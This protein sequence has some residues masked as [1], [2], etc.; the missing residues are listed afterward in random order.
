M[1]GGNSFDSYTGLEIA[2][3]GMSGRFPG[4][5][6]LAQFWENL[7]TGVESISF[8]SEEELIEAGVEPESMNAPGFVRARGILREAEYFDA[9][10]FGYSPAEANIMDPQLRLFHECAMAALEDAGYDPDSYN[11]LIGLYAGAADSIQWRARILT[12]EDC[13]FDMFSRSLYGN[14]DFLA[15]RISYKLNLKGPS[16]SIYT[17]CS[18]SLVAVHMACRS[19]LNGE[20]HMAAAG[21]VTVS[22]PP[23]SGYLYEEGMFVSPDGHCRAFDEA[24]AG[25]VFGDGVGTVVLK[26]LE[27]AI[28]DRDHVY[29]VVK[30]SAINNDGNLKVGFTAPSVKGQVEVIKVSHLM[31]EIEPESIGYV[32]AHG[33]GTTLGDP[34][35]IKALKTA[36]NS[37]KRGFCGLG[38]VKTNVGHLDAAA[39]VA[40]F[41]K[42]A[43]VLQHRLIP[44]TLNFVRA[45]PRLDLE[46]SPFYVVTE[47]REWKQDGG[48]LR[49]G[50]SSFGMGGTNAHVV[51]EEAPAVAESPGSR[52]WQL[53]LLSART[54]KELERLTERMVNFLQENPHICLA[55]AAFTLQVGRKA[56]DWRR[57]TVCSDIEDALL[58]LSSPTAD[59]DRVQTFCADRAERSVV[60][61]FP[62]QGSQYVNMGVELYRTEET[63][64]QEMD[65]CFTVLKSLMGVDVG[66]I[67]YPRDS[68]RRRSRP[69][70]VPDINRTEI[71]QPLI[72]IF[73]YA[74]ARLLM[75][76]GIEPDAMLGHSIG[77]YTAAC[78]AGVFSLED[79]LRL[80]VLRGQLMQRMPG[81]AMLGVSLSEAELRGL[82]PEGL[83][84]AA[85]N[86]P[87]SCVVSGQETVIDPFSRALS[88]KGIAAGR[89]H[90]SHA[91]HSAMM[92]P[93]L[94]E[95]AAEVEKVGLNPPQIAYIANVTGSWITDEAATDPGYWVQHVRRTVQFSAG[96]RELLKER[97]NIF[98]EVGPGRVL[99]T[100]VRKHGDSAVGHMT[101][102]L[103]R[104][105]QE[106][107]ADVGYLLT[108]LGQL[109]L[110][111][112]PIDWGGFYGEEKRRRISLPTYPFERQRYGKYMDGPDKIGLK[113]PLSSRLTEK[114]DFTEWFYIPAWKQAGMPPSASGGGAWADSQIWLLFVDEGG[115]GTRLRDCLVKYGQQV[116]TVAPAGGFNRLDDRRFVIHPARPKDYVRLIDELT[117]S[118]ERPQRI[119]HL[120][121]LRTGDKPEPY[122]SGSVKRDLELGFYSLLYLAQA[123][124]KR[125]PD[126]EWQMRIEVVANNVHSVTGEETL[127][128]GKA[129]VLGLV[130]VISQEYLDIR[131]RHIDMVMPEP[132]EGQETELV[133][134]LLAE[135]GPE[136]GD[137]VVAYRENSRW[138]P[139]FKAAGWDNQEIG[140]SPLR[141]QGTYVITGGLGDIGLALAEYLAKSAGARLM[142]IGRSD[143]PAP[144]ERQAWL[145]SHPQDDRLSRK[146]C[147]LRKIEASGAEV[148]VVRADVADGRQMREAFDLAEERFGRIDGV[149]HAAGVLNQRSLLPL[150]QFTEE[151]CREQFRSKIYG[152]LV[153][154]QVLSGR[155]IDFCL[156]TSSLS[157]V[158]AGLGHGVYSAAN[159]FMDTFTHIQN[160]RDNRGKGKWIS[161]NMDAWQIRKEN[162]A[163]ATPMAKALAGMA[164]TCREGVEAIRA[165]LSRGVGEVDQVVVSTGD[166]ENRLRQWIRLEM[167][168]E[169][170]SLYSRPGLSTPYVAPRN[171]IED[172]IV[173]IF[174]EFF[175]L[176]RVGTHDNFFDLGASSLDMVQLSKKMKRELAVDIPVTT[177]FQYP[178][179]HALAAFLQPDGEAA[180]KP[181]EDSG[182][183]EKIETG[184]RRLENRMRRQQASGGETAAADDR[185]ACH[186]VAV[187]GMAGRFPGAGGVDEFWENL[188][189]GVESLS[190]FSDRELKEMGER[191]DL[192]GDPNYIKVKGVLEDIEYFDPEFFGY[193]PPEAEIMDPQMRVMHECCWHALEQAGYDPLRYKG[194]IGLYVGAANNIDWQGMIFLAG[195]QESARRFAAQH[196]SDKDHISTRLSYNLNLR[197]PSFSLS[198]QCSTS[199]VA[200]HLACEGL[201]GGACDMALAGG[202]SV[203]LPGKSG[204]VYQEGMIVSPD[205]HCRAFD[206]GAE[207]TVFGN[208]A[209]IVV[210][211]R[212]EDAAADRDSLY[213]VI[214]G[215]AI[216]ND[217]RGKVGYTAPG[218][219]G[220]AEVIRTALCAARVEPETISYIETHGT[221][222]AL[223]DPIE[224]QA[225]TLAFNTRKRQYCR[226]G[227]VK[228][229]VGHL[230]SAAG[231]VGL[232]KTVLALKHKQIPASLHFRHPNPKIDF[233]NSP[234][235]VNTTLSDWV[236]DGFSLQPRRA[237]VSS[238][239]VGGTN[240]HVVLEEAPA[241]AGETAPLP[242]PS[243]DY[244]LI[245]LS[246]R[247]ESALETISRNLAEYLQQNPAPS[248]PDAAYTLQAGRRAFNYRRM[249][250]C[251]DVD[252]AAAA[253]LSPEPGKPITS[254]TGDDGVSLI[255]VFSGQD[256]LYVNMGQGLYRTERIFREEMD[257]CFE[258]LT[259]MVGGDVRDTLYAGEQPGLF[260]FEY[261]L[262][263]LLMRWGIKPH[264]VMG[265]GIGEYAA[266]CVAG[267]LSLEQALTILQKSG[268]KISE[269]E[270]SAPKIPFL[271]SVT[272]KFVGPGEMMDAGYWS[273]QSGE[274]IGFEKGIEALMQKGDRNRLFLEVGPAS[275]LSTLVG[276]YEKENQKKAPP[277]ID[278]VGPPQE[279]NSEVY[280][281]LEGLGRLWLSGVEIDWQAF[282]ADE[283]RYR[284]PLPL[285]PFERR[286]CWLDGMSRRP[287]AGLLL[288]QADQVKKMDMADWFYVP[289]WKQSTVLTPGR[290]ETAG[291]LS[292]LFF[293]DT[294]GMGTLLAE[295][296]AQQGCEVV[297]VEAGR[298]FGRLDQGRYTI[299]PAD[300][301]HYD[302]LLSELAKVG[303]LPDRIVHLWNITGPKK[304]DDLDLCFFS[305]VYLVKAVGRQNFDREIEI[306]VLT[307]HM[308][309][310]VGGELQN[311]RKAL[312]LGPVKVI[313]LEYPHIRCRC[314]DID[315]DT[316]AFPETS[317]R[318]EQLLAQLLIELTVPSADRLVAFRNNRRWVQV[319]E[320]IRLERDDRGQRLK[321]LRKKGVY[322]ITGGLGGIGLACAGH[323]GRG[324]GARLIL[325]GRTEFPAKEDWPA[326]LSSRPD[327]DKIS[328]K[329]RKLQEIEASGAE[330]LVFEADA[331]DE[332]RME[333]VIRL[334]EDRFG[335]INGVIHAAGVAGGGLI[336]G[337][338][339]ETLESVLTAKLEGT[340]V[341]DRLFSGKKPDFFFLCSSLSAILGEFGQVGYTAANAFLDAFAHHKIS[342]DGV[343][344]VSVNWDAWQAVGMAAEAYGEG[345]HSGR[346][347]PDEGLEVFERI[348]KNM[349]PHPQVAVSTNDLKSLLEQEGSSRA[350]GL[351][352]LQPPKRSKG[353]T[354]APRYRRPHLSTAFVAPGGGMEKRLAEIWQDHLGMEQVGIGDNFFELGAD[355][356]DII[357]V[358]ASIKAETGRELPL[359]VLYTYPTIGS[360]CEYLNHGDSQVGFSD[361]ESRRLE[362]RKTRDMSKLELKKSR[363]RVSRNV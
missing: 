43:L 35:E 319:F 355:S 320:P 306:T 157:S 256:S 332:E 181:E 358:N 195:P 150:E 360:L 315:M 117:G 180:G 246:A 337:R 312:A 26:P 260:V 177:L 185:D 77:E 192:L 176:D 132:G 341:L 225:L 39:G 240:A 302:L 258:I 67:L 292:W 141:Q 281:L 25:T 298:E 133:E 98:V 203:T 42:V 289:L 272:G 32:E 313:P 267:V 301:H 218:V 103:T 291:R 278:L 265:Q 184:R 348:I 190:F 257:R 198:T 153:L 199:L 87:K 156:L 59:T 342:T 53:I 357:Q 80:V 322:L 20:C 29:A 30:G 170:P 243:R 297:R 14:K 97:Q 201:L 33:T 75:K 122:S 351:T 266:A 362:K 134:R 85:V 48:P 116:L 227:S 310:V 158:L 347:S 335:E 343:W 95:F 325:T 126:S 284:V 69:D 102:N 349:Y 155:E 215:S 56:H 193:T 324:V 72:F 54:E 160:C 300:E 174:R 329:I 326:W 353:S 22:V 333:A 94:D 51:L 330:I 317:R 294:G 125:H 179:I 37:E 207:G 277:V 234:F 323:L 76:W 309:E 202:V 216:N 13:D 50:V 123:V 239:G 5:S 197:G 280:Y 205:G 251:A 228:T 209:G 107:V 64:R 299:N 249:A 112:Q 254:S 354:G 82:L 105:P 145:D 8:F 27:D 24:A 242:A 318:R 81:G 93:I 183:K 269:I 288:K 169:S 128:A 28:K 361:S 92:E 230:D 252:E 188:V 68:G 115:I 47:L 213:A 66:D 275:G 204:Y 10:F 253:L 245:L 84:L 18:T 138:L 304:G 273:R 63:F 352:A 1:S 159:I 16:S 11:G 12:A 135:L 224:I 212:L 101:V 6:N 255:F 163:V 316:E 137:R 73:E 328:R 148:L 79:A 191:E 136:S 295:R 151:D 350:E 46:N 86:A 164:M 104:H 118:Q 124:N 31:A 206:A 229:N 339:R 217:G 308:C 208:G 314:V 100:L 346:I 321:L 23:K 311:P 19:L 244:Q 58:T 119:V 194:L 287:E 356:M 41:I 34:I 340:W 3:I 285:T 152:V 108:R 247:S 220:Q 83:S 127:A 211:R 106:R 4:A 91:F 65:R 305:L 139:V 2:V 233:R 219:E 235:Y 109:W 74:L 232:I 71:A 120:W 88:H 338:K 293:V 264:A 263:R 9:R 286:C 345:V 200:C 182:R 186:D 261:A 142:L 7:K 283:Q 38:S 167:V 44:P 99:S 15:T 57:L 248:L 290:G 331:A 279:G 276:A 226:I 113:A 144:G 114:R 303:R 147:Q 262:A 173:E 166:L 55:D 161:V 259:P 270:I 70:R 296:V 52:D 222:T 129:A 111:G 237:G 96:V 140:R 175:G 359:F 238:F 165:V 131:C 231:V 130:K 268:E 62:G 89:L 363:T 214:K 162:E 154:A 110:Y 178:T 282:Y 171:R 45:N 250:V 334:A 271:S 17:A 336:Q 36:F 210:L 168:Q 274:T 61:L 21:G 146:I 327:S 223:G 196:L 172:Q 241:G 60:F 221:G 149:I 121:G 307:G 189:Q 78:L 187:I 40:G 49:A 344:T 143:F 236:I 90:T